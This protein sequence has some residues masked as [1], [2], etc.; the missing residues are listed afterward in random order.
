MCGATQIFI[1]AKEGNSSASIYNKNV[2]IPDPV[3]P[4]RLY[5]RKIPSQ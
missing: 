3:P 1:L 5:K 4:A 2:P